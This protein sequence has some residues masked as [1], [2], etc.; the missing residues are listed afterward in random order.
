M[1]NKVGYAVI[2]NKHCFKL[3]GDIRYSDVTGLQ[4]LLD[5]LDLAGA[6]CLIDLTKATHLDSTAMGC[7][8]Q[9][10]IKSRGAEASPPVIL[11]SSQHLYESLLSV[12]FDKVFDIQF[13]SLEQSESDFNPVQGEV[14]IDKLRQSVI[15]AHKTLSE[16]SESNQNLF[17]DVNELLNR[18]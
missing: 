12:C 17:Q 10:A 8:A 13:D 1:N 5:T 3:K 18:E 7:I 4:E 16:I 14:T 9:I 11:L 2:N 6:D 15:A